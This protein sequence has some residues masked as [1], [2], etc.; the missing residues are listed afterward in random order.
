MLNP[1]GTLASTLRPRPRGMPHFAER[2]PE[3]LGQAI[4]R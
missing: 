4:G 1:N 2:E 3:E